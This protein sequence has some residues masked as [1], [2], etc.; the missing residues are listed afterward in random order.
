MVNNVYNK[1][2]ASMVGGKKY[3]ITVG[4]RREVWNG[5]AYK[6][7]T[8]KKAWK[9]VTCS[10][11]TR[12]HCFKKKHAYGSKGLKQL[13]AKGYFTKKGHFGSVKKGKTAKKGKKGKSRGKDADI[14]LV[15]R[16]VNTKLQNQ[17]K[18]LNNIEPLNIILYIFTMDISNWWFRI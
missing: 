7:V 3:K 12:T 11:Q 5:T 13:H 18:T 10:K 1:D 15:K 2:G 8:V 17:E 9:E 16:K 6:P 4:S 14:N